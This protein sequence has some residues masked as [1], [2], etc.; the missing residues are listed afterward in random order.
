MSSALLGIVEGPG[1][2]E[3]FSSEGLAFSGVDVISVVIVVL[4]ILC[5]QCMFVFNR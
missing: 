5:V 3:V 1:V 2:V 4:L